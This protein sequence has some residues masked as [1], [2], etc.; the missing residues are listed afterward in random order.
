MGTALSA[1]G[2]AY[3]FLFI[4]ALVDAGVHVGLPRDMARVLALQTV[5]GSARL[6]KETGRHPAELKAMVTS[7]AGLP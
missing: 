1:S 4:E 3:V 7:P 6:A 2:P 5:L